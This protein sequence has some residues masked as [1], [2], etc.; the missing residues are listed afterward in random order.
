MKTLFK[1][2]LG[3]LFL[4]SPVANT[5]AGQVEPVNEGS[6]CMR[7][8]AITGQGVQVEAGTVIN[9][10]CVTEIEPN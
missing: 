2:L 8:I 3:I 6:F 4:V 1:T 5:Q 10:F 7:I 9:G